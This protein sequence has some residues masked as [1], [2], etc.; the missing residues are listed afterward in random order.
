M[1]E[2]R[3]HEKFLTYVAVNRDFPPTLARSS[4]MRRAGHQVDPLFCYISNHYF[5]KNPRKP[6]IFDQ[7]QQEHCEKPNENL[8]QQIQEHRRVRPYA[9][10][11]QITMLRLMVLSLL[12]FTVMSRVLTRNSRLRYGTRCTRTLLRTDV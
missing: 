3:L 9:N 10:R 5:L 4:S 7:E 1:G 11:R 8:L 2:E 12:I 6:T